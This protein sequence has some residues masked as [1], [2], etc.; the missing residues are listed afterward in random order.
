[1]N[2]IFFVQFSYHVYIQQPCAM[3]TFLF[4]NDRG[5]TY[6]K[7]E[8]EVQKY[9][10]RKTDQDTLFTGYSLMNNLQ[11]VSLCMQRVKLRYS[12][13]CRNILCSS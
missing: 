6:M 10:H 13:P 4:L 1:M 11:G 7:A 2:I 12:T 9:I 5:L 3:I 8:M